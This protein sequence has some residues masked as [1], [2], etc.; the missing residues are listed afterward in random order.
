MDCI[1]N[2]MSFRSLQIWINEPSDSIQCYVDN[3]TLIKLLNYLRDIKKNEGTNPHNRMVIYKAFSNYAYKRPETF[4]HLLLSQCHPSPEWQWRPFPASNVTVADCRRRAAPFCQLWARELL[5]A[6]SCD[7]GAAASIQLAIASR[8]LASPFASAPI[9]SGW[10][11]ECLES[12]LYQDRA[13]RFPLGNVL[14]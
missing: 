9:V 11:L 10:D 12:L 14:V 13:N 4:L 7:S 8:N 1:L 3:F 6:I 5:S 2:E